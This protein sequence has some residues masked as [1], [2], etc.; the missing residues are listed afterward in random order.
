SH[1]RQIVNYLGTHF[2]VTRQNEIDHSI[3]SSVGMTNATRGAHSPDSVG[4]HSNDDR[5]AQAA[6]M[7][8][9]GSPSLSRCNESV[10]AA[11]VLVEPAEKDIPKVA[12]VPNSRHSNA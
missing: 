5:R 12:L 8:G 10:A 9:Q 2:R 11:A 1:W 7:I 6:T 3:T 4:I